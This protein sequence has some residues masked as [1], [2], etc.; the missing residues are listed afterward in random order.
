MKTLAEATQ[1]VCHRG[2]GNETAVFCRGAICMAW[3]W[4]PLMC[5]DAWVAAVKQC[6]EDIGDKSQNRAKAAAH[7]NENREAYG[8]PTEPF[9]GFCGIAGKPL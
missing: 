5:D 6:A 2:A 4:E 9:R 3:R 7:V 1:M 8:L